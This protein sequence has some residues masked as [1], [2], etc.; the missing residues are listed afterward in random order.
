METNDIRTLKILEQVAS[1]SLSSQR[2]IAKELN[3]SLGL[4]NSFIKRLYTK[5]YVKVTTIPRNRIKYILTP[6]GMTEKTRLT[7]HFIQHSYNFYKAS[8]QKLRQLFKDLEDTG[9]RRLVLFGASDLAEIA[10]L[11]LQETQIEVVGVIDDRSHNNNLLGVHVLDVAQ[12]QELS[13]DRIL[14]ADGEDRDSVLDQ[15]SSNGVPPE[16]IIFIA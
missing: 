12:V 6:K 5:G 9:V 10:F 2:S 1:G 16:K 4:A 14:I 11:S 8:R 7:Y 3:V 13:F 15:L